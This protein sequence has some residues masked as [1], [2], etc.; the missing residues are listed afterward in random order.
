MASNYP[1][2]QYEKSADYEQT[3]IERNVDYIR[4]F[5][6]SRQERP[7]VIVVAG[8]SGVGKSTLINNFLRLEGDNASECAL[9]PTSV[10]QSVHCYDGII[11]SVSVRVIDIPGLHAHDHDNDVT[12]LRELTTVTE[13]IEVDVLFYC[14]SLTSRL[15]RIDWDNIDTLT[16]TFGEK[17]WNHAILVFTWA[18]VVLGEG[19]NLEELV[20]KFVQQMQ[21]QLVDRRRLNT[22]IRSI[23]SFNLLAT[24]E[25]AEICT[26]E[27][28]VA[29]PVSNKPEMPPEWRTQLLLQVIRV[30]RIENMPLFL[31]LH[32]ILNLDKK[33]LGKAAIGLV[34]GLGTGAVIGTGVGAAIGGIVGGVLTAPIGGFGAIPTAA[35]GAAFGSWIGTVIGGGG[36]GILSVI[37]TIVFTI[38]HRLQ[39][40]KERCK[41]IKANIEEDK[42]QGEENQ[43]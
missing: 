37:S 42:R 38:K 8:K 35:G 24:S 32:S 39:A 6:L 21:H 19:S 12:N 36:I 17:I 20:D 16:R 27:G 13:G 2:E 1:S 23:Y 30:C 15:D 31:K 3:D 10:T 5:S 22:T 26:Y 4:N 43:N 18:D 33:D 41:E 25:D 14:I 34:A 29:M 9:R 11:N 28:I 40:H 7:V